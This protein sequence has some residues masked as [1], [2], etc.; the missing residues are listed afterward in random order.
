MGNRSAFHVDLSDFSHRC[1]SKSSRLSLASPSVSPYA[2]ASASS[3][4]SAGVAIGPAVAAGAT[5]MATGAATVFTSLSFLVLLGDLQDRDGSCC[6]L[7]ILRHFWSMRLSSQTWELLRLPCSVFLSSGALALGL[8][9]ADCLLCGLQLLRL[10][11]G[12]GLGRT[13]S[14]AEGM[15]GT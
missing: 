7:G 4:S 15:R 14:R 2:C 5:V 9:D 10:L 8:G 12:L 11:L 13:V 1:F 6:D 3:P